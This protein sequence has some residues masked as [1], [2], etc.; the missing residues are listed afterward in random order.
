MHRGPLGLTV[1]FKKKAPHMVDDVLINKAAIIE[2]GV[3]RVREEYEK[4]PATFATD[5]T[6]QDSAI[7]NIQRACEHLGD[8]LECS[9]FILRKDA[10][11]AAP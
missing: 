2:R 4:D 7:L 8:F 9:A 3:A 5:F 6:R 1:M 11:G 10:V